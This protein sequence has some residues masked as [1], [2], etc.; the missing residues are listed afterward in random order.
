[1]ILIIA[2]LV[3]AILAWSLIFPGLPTGTVAFM[4]L[5]A[6]L[7]PMTISLLPSILVLDWGTKRSASEPRS[8]PVAGRRP[9][10]VP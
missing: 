6:M 9:H 7:L 2:V 4:V 5:M 3:V 8:V 10:R 1:M